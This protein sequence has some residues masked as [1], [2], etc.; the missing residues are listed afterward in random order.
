MEPITI[1]VGIVVILFVLI[2]S[3]LSIVQQSQA[4]VIERLGAFQAVWSVGLHMKV[5]FIDRIARKVSLKEPSFRHK[6]QKDMRICH[7]YPKGL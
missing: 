6:S 5:P 3:S 1:I 4:Y 7:Q 2:I